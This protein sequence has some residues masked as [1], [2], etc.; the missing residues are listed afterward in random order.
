M[1]ILRVLFLILLLKSE[2]LP[3]AHPKR[4]ISFCLHL[5]HP[6]CRKIHTFCIRQHRLCLPVS[7][8]DNTNP[9]TVTVR[10][11]KDRKYRSFDKSKPVSGS[12]GTAGIHYKKNRCPV[13]LPEP[14]IAR[15]QMQDSI[16]RTG[17]FRPCIPIPI[18]YIRP[19]CSCQIHL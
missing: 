9:V 4:C 7:E 13:P 14:D 15:I 2:C 10:T 16:C 5:F 12:L 6:L 18:S 19:E 1:Q 11:R 8:N 17:M 3:D